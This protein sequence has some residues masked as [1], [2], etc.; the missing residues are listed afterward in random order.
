MEEMPRPVVAGFDARKEAEQAADELLKWG[1][2][3]DDVVVAVRDHDYAA[4]GGLLVR[5]EDEDAIS[6]LTHLI[7]LAGV[8]E[9]TARTLAIKLDSMD[10]IVAVNAA[11]RDQEARTILRDHGGS[12]DGGDLADRPG[13]EE[14]RQI[15]RG[16]WERRTDELDRSWDEARGG[17]RYVYEKAIDPEFRGRAWKSAEPEL[18]SGYEGWLGERGYQAQSNNWE[19]LKETLRELWTPATRGASPDDI[20]HPERLHRWV[21][22]TRASGV[23][24]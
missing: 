8:P 1:F 11:G 15:L 21:R 23:V 20:V 10:A 7:G 22:L 19:W 9:A 12:F 2:A 16:H 5:S 6:H 18:Q 3:E 13:W 4:S 14:A 17:Y 24:E